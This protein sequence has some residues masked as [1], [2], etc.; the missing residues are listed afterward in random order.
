MAMATVAVPSEPVT[1]TALISWPSITNC[2]VP[3]VG[4]GV[5]VPVSTSEPVAVSGRRFR[6]RTVS[7]GEP[8]LD[9]GVVVVVVEAGVVVVVV[10]GGRVV[11][12]VDCGDVVVV[13]PRGVV[14]VV[15]TG[16][17]VV[18][19]VGLEVGA[20]NSASMFPSAAE[21]AK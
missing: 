13:V 19:V 3:P 5:I 9:D 20:L 16:G 8:E 14:V 2:T 21:P 15:V 4:A 7:T 11:V 18:V 10:V 17:V 12:V 6:V 1:G